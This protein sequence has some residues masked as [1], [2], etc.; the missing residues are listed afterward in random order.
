MTADK[1][2]ISDT[3]EVSCPVCSSTII[4]RRRLVGPCY[5]TGGYCEKCGHRQY[6]DDYALSFP[7]LTMNM[8]K[9]HKHNAK[10]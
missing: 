4:I 8:Q 2:P 1:Q 3:G 5:M 6:E 10:K 9:V 7:T